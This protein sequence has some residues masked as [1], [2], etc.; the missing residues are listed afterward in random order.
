MSETEDDAYLMA[1]LLPAETGLP[2]AV[3]ITPNEGYPDDVRVKVSTLHGGRGVWAGAASVAVRPQPRVV[4]G[5]LDSADFARV[6]QWIDLNRATIIGYW[7]G[8]IPTL[9]LHRHLQRLP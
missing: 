5:T 9:E 3:W 1:K 7:D 6:V 2:M 4:V 8:T